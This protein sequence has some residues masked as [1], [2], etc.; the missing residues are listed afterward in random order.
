MP[1]QQAP[2]G[3]QLRGVFQYLVDFGFLDLVLP[4]ILIFTLIFA[5]LQM[6]KV[7]KIKKKVKIGGQEQ[8]VEVGD[9]KI[10]SLI[11]LAIAAMLVIPHAIGMYPPEMDPIALMSSFLPSTVVVLAAVFVVMLLLGF[12]GAAEKSALQLLIAAIGVGLLVFLFV[13]NMFPRTFPAFYWLAD[14]T[15]QAVLFVFLIMGL[16]V[17]WVMKPESA[18][19][20]PKSLKEWMLER[21]PPRT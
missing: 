1:F 9:R 7:F 14:P 20:L 13:L 17:Y 15:I 2:S 16:I 10:N 8:E 12:A 4:F 18:K 3:G 19:P 21:H 6:T 11:A 5:I